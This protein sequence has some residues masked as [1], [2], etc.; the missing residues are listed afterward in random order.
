MKYLLSIITPFIF[1]TSMSAQVY[2]PEFTTIDKLAE[3]NLG[4]SEEKVTEILGIPPY[5]VFH[6]VA[7]KCK[8]LSWHYKHKGHIISSKDNDKSPSL[9]DGQTV[10]FNPNKVF[11][12]FSENDRRLLSYFT[13]EG[14]KRSI[15][16]IELGRNMQEVCDEKPKLKLSK[17]KTDKIYIRSLNNSRFGAFFKV[18]LDQNPDSKTDILVGLQYRNIFKPFINTKSISLDAKILYNFTGKVTNPDDN[19]DDNTYQSAYPW[20]NAGDQEKFWRDHLIISLPIHFCYNWRSFSLG[21]G[22][23]FGFGNEGVGPENA[24]DELESQ[25]IQIRGKKDG[26]DNFLAVPVIKIGYNLLDKV[27]IEY[28]MDLSSKSQQSIGI[29]Y[30]FGF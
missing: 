5:D 9:S 22:V 18:A 21:A 2:E 6:D 19:F 23:H 16:L 7:N 13:E 3:I 20:W 26:Y 24:L 12:K 30:Y 17:S 29:G 25:I 1:V 15:E 28:N 27:N 14:Q 10:F 8:V 11:F 4:M